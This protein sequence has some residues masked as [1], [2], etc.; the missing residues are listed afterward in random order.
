MISGIVNCRVHGCTCL[1]ANKRDP[2]P[3]IWM[4]RMKI[5]E[6][7]A[8]VL[9]GWVFEWWRTILEDSCFT[10]ISQ[11]RHW[12][13]SV[14]YAY[15]LNDGAFAIPRVAVAV[16]VGHIVILPNQWIIRFGESG[17]AKARSLIKG[18]KRK[19]DQLSHLPLRWEHG[20]GQPCDIGK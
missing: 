12:P 13:W 11:E 16:L 9:R 4:M 17:N 10:Y 14:R 18:G 2:K 15:M 20:N 3:V 5:L 1:A 6:L 8:R 19:V 7:E